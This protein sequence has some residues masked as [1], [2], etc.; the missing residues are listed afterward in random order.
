MDSVENYYYDVC[1]I[2]SLK[3]LLDKF[4]LINRHQFCYHFC[5][6]EDRITERFLT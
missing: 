5:L 1:V 2:C 6:C 4:I 3:N